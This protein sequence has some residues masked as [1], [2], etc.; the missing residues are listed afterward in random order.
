[1]RIQIV[2][3]KWFIERTGTRE[4]KDIFSSYNVISI[5]T[6]EHKPTGFKKE[7]VPFTKSYKRKKNV[8][9]LNFHDACDPGDSVILMSEND[10]MKVKKFVEKMDM[11]KSLII[12]CT[13]GK[14]R[15]YTTGFC[16]NVYLNRILENNMEDYVWF[17]NNNKG[18]I[19]SWVKK[20]LFRVFGIEKGKG[21]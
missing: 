11:T 18:Y 16:L 20:Q 7:D 14:S 2:P 13:A 19:N 12:H 1:M 4:E 3:R 5:I 15:S 8:L 6:P 21:K 17:I 9:V 10:A